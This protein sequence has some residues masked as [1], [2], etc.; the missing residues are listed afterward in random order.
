MQT[1][2]RSDASD[3]GNGTAVVEGSGSG[4]ETAGGKETNGMAENG[5]V[6]TNGATQDSGA[7]T[8]QGV[9]YGAIV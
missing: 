8:L 7:N 1:A 4:N 5:G 9:G 2:L 3:G 6:D